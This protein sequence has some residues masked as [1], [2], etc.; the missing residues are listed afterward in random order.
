VI[1]FKDISELVIVA[2]LVGVGVLFLAKYTDEKL[3]KWYSEDKN[4]TDLLL[5]VSASSRRSA[6]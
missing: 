1:R 6:S 5:P 4:Y 3:K 2:K